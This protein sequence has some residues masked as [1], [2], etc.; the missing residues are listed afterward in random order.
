MFIQ[1]LEFLFGSYHVPDARLVA[2]SSHL[3]LMWH[4]EIGLL[5]LLVRR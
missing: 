5:L 1:E 2:Y 3:T 4:S